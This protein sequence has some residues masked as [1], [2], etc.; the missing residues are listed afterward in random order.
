MCVSTY[1]HRHQQIG[2][3][4]LPTGRSSLDLINRVAPNTPGIRG[5]PAIGWN[6]PG[7]PFPTCPS[8]LCGGASF[9]A[10]KMMFCLGVGIT[11]P[12]MRRP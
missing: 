5:V 2:K 4:N 6:N 10:W 1:Q 7:K 9:R 11:I 12:Y 8:F 3:T